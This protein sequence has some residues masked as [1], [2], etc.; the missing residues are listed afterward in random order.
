MDYF[1]EFNKIEG[2][3][4]QLRKKKYRLKLKTKNLENPKFNEKF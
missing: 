1:R 3:K 2:I 4:V